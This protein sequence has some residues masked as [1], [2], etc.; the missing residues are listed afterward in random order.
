MDVLCNEHLGEKNTT[1]NLHFF[2]PPFFI[3]W[4]W[5]LRT[6][7]SWVTYSLYIFFFFFC[8]AVRVRKQKTPVNDF[9]RFCC[10]Y[11]YHA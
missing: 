8:W 2:S 4:Y 5:V 1:Q 9:T 11:L 10:I 7:V 6:H 3:R